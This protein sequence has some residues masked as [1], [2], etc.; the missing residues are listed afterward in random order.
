M[1]LDT[2]LAQHHNLSRNRAKQLIEAGLV[3]VHENICTKV[4]EDVSENDVITLT[5]DRRVHWVSRS[6]LKLHGFLEYHEEV[7]IE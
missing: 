2:F 1:R 3:F 7:L 6:A 4:S 5:E